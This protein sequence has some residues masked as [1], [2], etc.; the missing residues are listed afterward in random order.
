MEPPNKRTFQLSLVVIDCWGLPHVTVQWNLQIRELFSCLQL[1]IVE[2][3]SS[4][5][6]SIYTLNV[7]LVHFSQSIIG[8]RLSLF[9]SLLYRRFHCTC[10]QVRGSFAR[11]LAAF[12]GSCAPDP[13]NLCTIRKWWRPKNMPYSGI[14]TPNDW[15]CLQIQF[16]DCNFELI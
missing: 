14:V 16:K 13:S 2:R 11:A 1:S 9:R 3:L 7:Q 10:I 6:R 15:R 12:S 5:Q 4:S 8:R